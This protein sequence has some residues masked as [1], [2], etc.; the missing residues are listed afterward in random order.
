MIKMG[1]LCMG[2]LR[3]R[4]ICV[5]RKMSGKVERAGHESVEII[6]PITDA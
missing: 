4:G 6:W 3:I 2:V 5:L 1:V